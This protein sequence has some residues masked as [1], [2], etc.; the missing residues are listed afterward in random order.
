MRSLIPLASTV[1]RFH[2]LFRKQSCFPCRHVCCNDGECSVYA[3]D[4]LSLSGI[5]TAFIAM[6][7]EAAVKEL[8]VERIHITTCSKGLSS[9]SGWSYFQFLDNYPK[10]VVAAGKPMLGRALRLGIFCCFTE[11]DFWIMNVD[12]HIIRQLLS[13]WSKSND[14]NWII[15]CERHHPALSCTRSALRLHRLLGNL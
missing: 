7:F 8:V 2:F 11:Q 4:W 12:L 15:S 1:S 3:R 6:Q 14:P 5:Q 10:Q 13:M 9:G